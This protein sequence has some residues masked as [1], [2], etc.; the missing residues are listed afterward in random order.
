VIQAVNRAAV[1]LLGKTETEVVG[2]PL[3]AI[4]GGEVPR[5]PDIPSRG[6][7]HLHNVD[8]VFRSADG[9]LVPTVV[10]ASVTRGP[11]GSQDRVVLVARDMRARQRLIEETA[12]AEAHRAK[13]DELELAYRNL[14]ETQAQLVQ[15]G[16]L[17]AVGQLAGA[18]A[19]ELNNPLVS[20]VCFTELLRKD[21]DADDPVEE[22]RRERWTRYVDRILHGS[23]RCK[24]VAEKLLLFARSGTG[25]HVAVNLEDVVKDT[26]SLV[27]ALLKRQGT[28]IDLA[29]E[30]GLLVLGNANSL[31]QVVMNLVLN[32]AQAL[33]SEG[34]VRICSGRQDGEIHL[35]VEDDG[36]GIAPEHLDRVFEPFFTT[37]PVGEGTGLG[38]SIVY[39]VMKDHHSRISVDSEPGQG[40]RFT[41]VFEAYDGT[42]S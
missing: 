11:D 3:S 16:K 24:E 13:A 5:L 27:E 42:T 37:K 1:D 20:V 32:A 40:A 10:N 15:S 23:Q 33:G 6:E 2:T 26:L 18:V 36:P 39:G 22:A 28:K 9:T 29:L 30:P 19:H 17:A 34:I 31:Q 35:V 12:R 25:R 41:L 14:R 4:V 38:L 21:L 7:E 8:I